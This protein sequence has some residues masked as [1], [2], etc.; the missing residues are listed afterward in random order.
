MSTGSGRIATPWCGSASAAVTSE[1][2]D[3]PDANLAAQFDDIEVQTGV[4]PRYDTAPERFGYLIRTL[5]RQTGQRVVVLVDEYDKPILDALDHGLHQ[6]PGFGVSARW[7]RRRR[8]AGARRQPQPGGS[9]VVHSCCARGG[10]SGGVVSD[11]VRFPYARRPPTEATAR[12]PSQVP[13]CTGSV[14]FVHRSARKA[15]ECAVRGAARGDRTATWATCAAAGR[16]PGRTGAGYGSPRAATMRRKA[17]VRGVAQRRPVWGTGA[18]AAVA[19]GRLGVA[20]EQQAVGVHGAPHHFADLQHGAAYG[21]QHGVA[22]VDDHALDGAHGERGAVGDGAL[23]YAYFEHVTGADLGAER[24]HGG[25][26]GQIGPA[27]LAVLGQDEGA[28]RDQGE[29]VGGAHHAVGVGAAGV[30]LDG[31]GAP[32]VRSRRRIE[33]TLAGV[34][35]AENA[36]DRGVGDGEGAPL[37]APGEPAQRQVDDAGGDRQGPASW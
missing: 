17:A 8:Q 3:N 37:A 14:G 11:R 2:R 28:H 22:Q 16:M 36:G 13:R 26:H 23:R 25:E 1:R 34:A 18:R 15:P 35:V 29:L 19:G 27:Y 30:R 7:R 6:P 21:E 9:P 5:R 24:F 33:P 20:D 32:R 12:Q 31:D 4:S 10:G